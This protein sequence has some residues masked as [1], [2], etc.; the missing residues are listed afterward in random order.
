METQL[1]E[2]LELGLRW[3]AIVHFKAADQLVEAN[4]GG[5]PQLGNVRYTFFR[6]MELYKGIVAISTNRAD[7]FDKEFVSI[8]RLTFAFSSL[9]E[10]QRM[11]VWK[12]MLVQLYVSLILQEP[13]LRSN[14]ADLTQE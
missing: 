12:A 10:E 11:A 14:N 8:I 9:T 5:N 3:K 2:Y 7:V 4:D 1:Q 6:E 13:F